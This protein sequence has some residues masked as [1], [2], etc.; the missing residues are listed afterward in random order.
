MRFSPTVNRTLTIA[1]TLLLLA[2]AVPLASVSHV[3]AQQS[4]LGAPLNKVIVYKDLVYE[5]KYVAPL[6]TAEQTNTTTTNSSKPNA[7]ASEMTYESTLTYKV[8]SVEGPL[9]NVSIEGRIPPGVAVLANG[10]RTLDILR[11]PLSPYYPYIPPQF[12]YPIN[13]TNI[14]ELFVTQ[15][16]VLISTS[17]NYSIL[18]VSPSFANGTLVSTLSSDAWNGSA[19]VKI[20]PNG[21]LESLSMST[22]NG[23]TIEMTLMNYSNPIALSSN[24][25]PQILNAASQPLLYAV[26][27][28]VPLYNSLQVTGYLQFVIPYVITNDSYLAYYYAIRPQGGQYVV[29]PQGVSG[30]PVYLFIKVVNVTRDPSVILPQVGQKVVRWG[31][32]TLTLVGTQNI[33]VLS[34]SYSTFVYTGIENRTQNVTLWVTPSGVVVRELVTSMVQ[35]APIVE[36]ELVKPVLVP[37]TQTYPSPVSFGGPTTLPYK[38]VNPETSYII[39][40]VF[41]VVVVVVATL[42]RL[43]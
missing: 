4:G 8:V 2:Y 41:A 26:K 9:L 29:S 25:G 14:T 43:R 5:I 35:K 36:L 1:L 12:L 19:Q 17:D 16:G 31:N 40:V 6:K 7:T 34:N 10:T 33:T 32:T 37:A 27:T 20:G 24:A 39:A 3:E 22:A 21:L 30:V 38:V 42:V 13:M 18:L 11:E 23:G 28:Y 15:L